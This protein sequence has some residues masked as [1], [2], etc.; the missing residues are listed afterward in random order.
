MVD[1][2]AFIT[3]TAKQLAAVPRD[4][5]FVPVQNDAPKTLTPAQIQSYNE[6]GYLLPF[7]GLD[8]SEI[9]TL[10]A[11]FDGVLAAFTSLGR[12]S[13]SISTAHL[14]FARIYELVRH[15][16]LLAPV[17]DLLGPD[18]V[19]WGAHFFCKLP[20]DGKRVAWHQ[21][22]AYW[23]MSPSRTVTVWLAI[24]D[25][26]PANANMRF[27]P[28]SHVHGPIG[29]RDTDASQEV[30]NLVIED[31]EALGDPPVDVSLKAGQFSMHADLLVHGS[32]ANNSDR[33]RCG[34]TIR[35][36]A[37]PVKAWYGWEQKGVVVRGEDR[38]GHW[39]N[40]PCPEV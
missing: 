26:D 13:Y 36:A 5:A 40:A 25:A 23:P 37:A 2:D 35:Y 10:R 28:R 38:D 32:E 24:D 14:R 22:A 39:L 18:L 33:R 29:F 21:D 7:D 34:L 27:I 9:G 15:P 19:A 12:D 30:L 1:A 6:M 16:A 17:E 3:P 8:T 11:F 4:L 31:A 20:H